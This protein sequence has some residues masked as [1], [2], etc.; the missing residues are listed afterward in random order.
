MNKKII[1]KATALV[2]T[3]YLFVLLTFVLTHAARNGVE[4]I[5]ILQ[6]SIFIA[7]WFAYMCAASPLLLLAIDILTKAYNYIDRRF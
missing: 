6:M 2:I 1:L 7:E 4:D 3:A 5:P